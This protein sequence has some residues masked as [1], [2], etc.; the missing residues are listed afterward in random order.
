MTQSKQGSRVFTSTLS[1]AEIEELVWA[2]I[3]DDSRVDRTEVGLQVEHGTVYLDGMVDSAAERQAVQQD[4]ETVVPRDKIV[5]RLSLKNFVER[6][7]EEL[8]SA[9]RAAMKRDIA[10]D[11]DGVAVECR[12]GVVNLS[13][14]VRGYADKHAVE[15]LAWWMPGVTDVVSRVQV[16]G[17]GDPRDEP[18]Y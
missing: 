7:N 14:H 2:A 13:G 10:L 17:I 16:D 9:V 4:A 6:T 8:C 5:D 3:E 12:D 18:D 11:A 1:D 15:C